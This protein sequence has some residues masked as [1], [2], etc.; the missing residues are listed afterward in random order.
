MDEILSVNLTDPSI[1]QIGNAIKLVIG[2][3]VMPEWVKGIHQAMNI[4]LMVNGDVGTDRK[5]RGGSL[6]I[7]W[8]W[9]NGFLLVTVYRDQPQS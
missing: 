2:F 5:A 9:V 7:R 1:E 6:R 8:E 4:P 3:E